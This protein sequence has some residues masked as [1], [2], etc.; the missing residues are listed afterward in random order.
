MS[1]GKRSTVI[2]V[3]TALLAFAGASAQA[4]ASAGPVFTVTVPKAQASAPLDGRIILLVSKDLTREPK[5][6][7]A[8]NAPLDSP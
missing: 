2:A 7:V 4:H 8:P 1:L 5:S 3:L 6:H